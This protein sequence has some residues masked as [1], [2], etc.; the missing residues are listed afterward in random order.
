MKLFAMSTTMPITGVT[1]RNVATLP[2]ESSYYIYVGIEIVALL[3]LFIAGLFFV[4]KVIGKENNGNKALK[5]VSFIIPIIG[6]ILFFVNMKKDKSIALDYLKSG[7]IGIVVWFLM[8]LVMFLVAFI[9][10]Y[11]G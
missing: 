10:F 3:L 1:T 11:I 8:W 7:I 5:A 4:L 6:I 9:R 2:V